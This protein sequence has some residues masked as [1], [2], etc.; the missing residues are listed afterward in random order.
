MLTKI[1]YQGRALFLTTILL[2][3]SHGLAQAQT[4]A[5]ASLCVA[6]GYVLG[7][8]NGVFNDTTEAAEGMETLSVLIGDT[9]KG[10]RINSELFYNTS[11]KLADRSTVTRLEDVA[12]V[13][14]QRANEL[15]GILANRW[16]Y[17]WELLRGGQTPLFD[18]LVEAVPAAAAVRDGLVTAFLGRTVA[19]L[20]GFRS[21]P[22]TLSDYVRHNTR[23]QGLVTERKKLLLVGHSQ[24]NLF[25]NS[26]YAKAVSLAGASS[27]KAVHIAPASV[28]LSGEYTLANIDLVIGALRTLAPGQTKES[29]VT[30]AFSS[31]DKS[32]H[33]LIDTYLDS[34]RPAARNQIKGQMISALD[35]LTTP[36][37]Q[38]GQTG[39][40]TLTLTW[41]GP[42]DVDLHT[43]EPSGAQVFYNNRRGP[44]GFLDTDNTTA[45]GPEHYYASCDASILQPG[46]YRVGINNYS[47]ATGRTATV[48]VASVVSGE[49]LTKT[50]SVGPEKGSG[51]NSSPIPVFNVTVTKSNT[52]TFSLSAQ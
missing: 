11:G 5:T 45:N 30:L 50:L 34:S 38:Q 21:M 13:F 32:G 36:A 33:K 39:F 7:F 51:G 46:V 14:S 8:F 25:L 4:T 23:I 52:G 24:G 12:E 47:S 49:L 1:F 42:G 9:Y 40:F 31:T 22:P 6:S 15:D 27:V 19:V 17:F 37:T 10:E 20:S 3:L 26:A 29:N 35:S 2:G 16:E 44:V 41:D 48:Q 18:R 28:I 43:F